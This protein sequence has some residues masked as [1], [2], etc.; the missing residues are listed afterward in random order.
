MA[1]DVRVAILGDSSSF[2]RTVRGV[3]S[4]SSRM[5]RALNG[6]KTAA[7]AAGGAF[8]AMQIVRFGS[9]FVDA[10]SDMNETVSKTRAVFKSSATEIER[11]ADTA[12]VSMG[13]SKQEALE[14]SSSFG[15]MFLQLGIGQDQAV[16]MSKAMTELA[17]DFASFHNADITEVLIAQQAAFRGEY[18]AVQ[19]FVPTINAAAVEQQALE[20]GLAATTSELTAQDKALATQTLLL[21][22]AGDAMGDFDRTSSGAANQQR[23]LSAAWKDGQAKIGQALL[24]AVTALTSFL[25]KNLPTAIAFATEWG[26]RMT[27]WAKT[28]EG[29]MR[30]L[31]VVVGTIMVGAMVAYTASA[32]SAA[33]ATIAAT[34]PVLA[35][36]AAIVALAAGLYYAY[37]NWGWF[38][39]GVWKAYYALTVVV[40]WINTAVNAVDR[41]GNAIGRVTGPLNSL[42]DKA[43]NL[44]GMG[45]PGIPGSGLIPGFDTGGVV[46]GPIGAPKLIMAH[47]GETILPTHKTGGGG[48]V[49]EI[50]THIMLDGRE[51][52]ESVRRHDRGLA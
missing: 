3:Q 16:D 29:Q 11:W 42:L 35:A 23:I 34:W 18:D 38:R 10:A 6:V 47:G 51:V 36:V 9:Q 1:R 43:G 41:L 33:A 52:A 44:G 45:I 27:E 32:V 49:I 5:D 14:A 2:D 37:N 40:G 21:E 26:R 39:D 31:A 46:P 13:Q 4:G 28:H 12:A 30:V 50:H 48:E 17:S 15:N 20:M 8:A 25:A 7:V 24:P 22:G 19:R